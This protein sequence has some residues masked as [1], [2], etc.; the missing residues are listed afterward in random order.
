MEGNPKPRIK[1]IVGLGNKGRDYENTRHNLGFAIVDLLSGQSRFLPGNGQYYYC[2]ILIGHYEIALLKPTTYMNRSGVAVTEFAGLNYIAPEE[3]LVIA[4]DFNL[5]LGKI[6][7]RESGSDGG[8]NGLASLIYHLQTETIPRLRIGIGPLP[9][10]AGAED[11]VL[12][13]FTV[14]ELTTVQESIQRTS[15]A[16]KIWVIDGY[17]KAAAPYNG[18]I[19][20]NKTEA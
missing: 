12:K 1:L 17:A 2:R 20:I 16:V 11:F 14:D 7:L 3:I 5:P 19:E 18:A 9:E 13:K 10:G 6:R 8:H 4:D 15:E